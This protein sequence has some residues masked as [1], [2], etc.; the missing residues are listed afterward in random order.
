MNGVDFTESRLGVFV[1]DSIIDEEKLKQYRDLAFS[2]GQN[3]ELELAAKAI[4]SNNATEIGR[5]IDEFMAAKRQ[6]E[7]QVEENKMAMN[8][9]NIA[10][11]AEDRKFQM[12]K[13]VKEEELQ[14]DRELAV[15]N[16]KE[17]KNNYNNK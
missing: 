9:A 7:Q 15:A 6:F 3:G 14:K 13:L 10:D 17:S 1:S 2:A 16:I 12:D 5:H 11:K 8:Q 4:N